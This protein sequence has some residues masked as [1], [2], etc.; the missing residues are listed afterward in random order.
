MGFYTG[1][2]LFLKFLFLSL[3]PYCTFA[4]KMQTSMVKKK[5]GQHMHLS[6]SYITLFTS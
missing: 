4:Q 5:L 6:L 2:L 3:I 1:L